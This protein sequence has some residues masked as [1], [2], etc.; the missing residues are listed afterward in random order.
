MHTIYTYSFSL[1]VGIFSCYFVL[2]LVVCL[3][4]GSFINYVVSVSFSISFV[5]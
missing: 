2:C 5:I 4:D 1:G 3:I